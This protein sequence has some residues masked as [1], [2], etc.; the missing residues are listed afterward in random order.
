MSKNTIVHFVL[1]ETRLDNK[2]FI[3]KWESFV[4]PN[5]S[6][7]NVILQESKNKKLLRYIAQ[8]RY[9]TDEFQFMLTKAVKISNLKEAEIKIKQLG[10]YWIAQQEKS[11]DAG[12][13]ECKVFAFIHSDSDIEI[14]KNIQVQTKLN[15]YEA[16]YENCEYNYIFEF[17]VTNLSV[18]QLIEQLNQ[19]NIVDIGIYKQCVLHVV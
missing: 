7:D 14:Y 13:N 3:N 10:G 2:H 1:F 19:Y 12:K 17:F 15:I 18:S 4:A 8:Y 11:G 9:D 16:Y 5:S 6:N